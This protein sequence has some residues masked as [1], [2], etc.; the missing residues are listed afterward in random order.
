MSTLPVEFTFP[1][2]SLPG[3]NIACASIN[4]S[5]DLNFESNHTFSV[6]LSLIRL[7]P[8]IAANPQPV[9]D[10]PGSANVTIIDNDGTNYVYTKTH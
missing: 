10:S 7:D 3:I 4:I 2:G 8:A 6:E 9:I 5:D 1:A